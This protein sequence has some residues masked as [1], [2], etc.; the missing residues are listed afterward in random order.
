LAALRQ[1][2]YDGLTIG[3]ET[4]DDEALRFMDKGYT[5]ADIVKQCRRLDQT[6]IHYSFF[7]L[8]GISGAGRGEMG[9]KAAADVCNQLHPS[10][11]GVNMLTVC[12]NPELYREIQAGSWEEAGEVKKYQEIRALLGNLDI[13]AQFCRPGRVKC[14]PVP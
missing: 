9:A 12:P 1:A 4:G 13:P 6:G 10:L 11:I 7:Y 8:A 5:A 14:F 2:G 3:V